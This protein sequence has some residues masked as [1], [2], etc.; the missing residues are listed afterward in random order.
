MSHGDKEMMVGRSRGN[1]RLGRLD[2]RES[3]DI[4]YSRF[5]SDF[6]DLVS[7]LPLTYL[8][9]EDLALVGLEEKRLVSE[10]AK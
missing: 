10:F 9:N 2:V 3:L 5:F 6:S 8:I 4:S 1:L 7:E